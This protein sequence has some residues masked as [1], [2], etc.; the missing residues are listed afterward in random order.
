A[1]QNA[2]KDVDGF[3]FASPPAF[4]MHD[5]SV[6]GTFG[7]LQTLVISRFPTIKL[8][9][10]Q[11]SF[12]SFQQSW[13]EKLSGNIKLFGFLKLGSFSEGAWGSSYEAGTDDS[14]F[15]VTFTPSPQVLSVPQ[16]QQLAFVIAGAVTNP[17]T[18]V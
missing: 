12:Q 8:T 6:G 7:L 4:N 15:S 18:L 17:G 13:S 9:Y 11:A 16:L 10:H 14:T 1:V 5:I 3:K 2:D